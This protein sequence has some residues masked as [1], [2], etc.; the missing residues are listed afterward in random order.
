MHCRAEV[1]QVMLEADLNEAGFDETRLNRPDTTK[2]DIVMAALRASLLKK[3]H[4]D[5]T[6]ANRDDAALALFLE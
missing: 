2:R 3:F 6:D 1:L 5:V 4:N